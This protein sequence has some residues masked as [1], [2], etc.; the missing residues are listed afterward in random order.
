[1]LFVNEVKEKEPLPQ[2][3]EVL[4]HAAARAATFSV[5]AATRVATPQVI[6][7]TEYHGHFNLIQPHELLSMYFLWLSIYIAFQ[8]YAFF[9]SYVCSRVDYFR[10]PVH[11][12]FCLDCFFQSY[13]ATWAT[14]EK[15]ND[16]DEPVSILCSLYRPHLMFIVVTRFTY[17]F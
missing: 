4:S 7:R 15:E 3:V 8:S 10:F 17:L 6:E 14:S 11:C 13:I 2:L 12:E 9:Q 5:L 1:M 16:D